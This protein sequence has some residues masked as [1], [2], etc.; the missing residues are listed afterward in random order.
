MPRSGGPP[1][2]GTVASDLEHERAGAHGSALQ[3]SAL[4]G[5]PQCRHL[6]WCS[7]MIRAY[8]RPESFTVRFR[9]S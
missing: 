3:S 5:T 8:S 9:V 1:A 7:A 4:S 6:A 2:R